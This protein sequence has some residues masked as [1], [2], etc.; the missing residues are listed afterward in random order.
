MVPFHSKLLVYQRVNI[1]QP[2]FFHGSSPLQRPPNGLNPEAPQSSAER[3]RLQELV[4]K[5]RAE[6][7]E[8]CASLVPRMGKLW[9]DG[10]FSLFFL[11]SSDFIWFKLID[12][13]L[14]S[15]QLEISRSSIACRGAHSDVVCG[16]FGRASL[17]RRTLGRDHTACLCSSASLHRFS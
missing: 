11:I 1:F 10:C 15:S 17:E 3:R 7:A 14:C 6:D 4:S 2:W 16:L 13:L 5:W 12:V 9:E 8:A